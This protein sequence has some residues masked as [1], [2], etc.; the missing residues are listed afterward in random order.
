MYYLLHY[1]LFFIRILFSFPGKYFILCVYIYV[2]VY[3]C[4]CVCVCVC[5]CVCDIKLFVTT[6]S[7]FCFYMK[8]EVKILKY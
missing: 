5:M 2:C 8:Y 6:Y 4:V 1:N 7:L 3:V